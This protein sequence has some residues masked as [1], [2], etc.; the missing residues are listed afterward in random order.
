MRRILFIGLLSLI[1]IITQ[2]QTG[3]NYQA[4]ARD[5]EGKPMVNQDI[6]IKMSIKDNG[7]EL[8]SEKHE[9]TT[10]AFGLFNLIIGQGAE[11]VG[12]FDS[13][14]WSKTKLTYEISI[15]DN[16]LGDQPFTYVP[17]A[18]YADYSNSSS[19]W[20]KIGT[21]EIHSNKSISIGAGATIE[22]SLVHIHCDSIVGS[23]FVAGNLLELST[24][25]SEGSLVFGK[26]NK[27]GSSFIQSASNEGPSKLVVGPEGGGLKVIGDPEG[28]PFTNGNIL[29]LGRANASGALV[30]G[31]K[32][33]SDWYIQSAGGAGGSTL[34]LNP[35]GGMVSVPVLEVRG[36]DLVEKVH[37]KDDLQPGEVIVIDPSQPNHV[38]RSYKAYDRNVLGVVSGAGGVTHG[39][40]LSQ[41]GVLDGNVAFA[42]S[43]RV[44]VKVVG[45]VKP[46]DLLTTSNVPGYAMKAENRKKRDGAVIGKALSVIDKNRNVLMLVL[47]K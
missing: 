7:D 40:V 36:A 16:S 17:F 41:E 31:K 13:I 6:I 9:V 5:L 42:I 47:N 27:D 11:D 19:E 23:P 26:L 3:F 33:A 46:G 18:M 32:N 15:N 37:S 4:V 45:E 12:S 20:Q 1:G 29:E 38:K 30:F 22:S 35:E 25:G 14:D 43:G 10:N 8:Y 21:N 28:D 24:S 39:M 44:Y 2:A 34:V